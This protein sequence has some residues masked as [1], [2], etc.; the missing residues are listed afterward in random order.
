METVLNFVE[1][2]EAAPDGVTCLREEHLP[3]TQEEPPHGK[4][5][6]ATRE[7]LQGQ[8]G[9]TGRPEAH[10]SG[11]RS[12]G[13]QRRGDPGVDPVGMGGGVRCVG[14]RSPGVGGRAR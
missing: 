2:G 10:G 12:E 1:N 11:Q 13:R 8:G 3:Y 9:V 6:S 5:E 14:V 4:D 7:T